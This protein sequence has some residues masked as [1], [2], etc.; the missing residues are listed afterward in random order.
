MI[1]NLSSHTVGAGVVAETS[2]VIANVSNSLLGDNAHGVI[3][4]STSASTMRLSA[5]TITG[6]S[7]NGLLISSGSVLS[8]GNNAIRGNAGNETRRERASARNSDRRDLT[9]PAPA[10]LFPEP[11]PA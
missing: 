7:I 2:S 4:G 8:Y 1:S 3:N 6:N 5:N 10:R 11:A 9:G